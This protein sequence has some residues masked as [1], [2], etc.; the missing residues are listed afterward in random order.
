M[1]FIIM[2]E[3]E[4]HIQRGIENISHFEKNSKISFE[5]GYFLKFCLKYRVSS[6]TIVFKNRKDEMLR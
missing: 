1:R 3:M 4:K 2:H 5:S 6:S